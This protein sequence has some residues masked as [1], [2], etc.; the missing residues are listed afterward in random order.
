MWAIIERLAAWAGPTKM[1]R[2]NPTT[3]NSVTDWMTRIMAPRTMRAATEMIMVLLGPM[4][5]STQANSAA[6]RPAVTFMPMPKMMRSSKDM[7]KVPA[8]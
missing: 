1:P 8:A 5:S 3:Q 7:P 6:P 4:R 2:L